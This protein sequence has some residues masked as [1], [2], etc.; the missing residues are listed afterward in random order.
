[1][2]TVNDWAQQQ[3]GNA[4]LGDQ[5]RTRRAVALGAQIATRPAAGLPG[6]SQ[7]WSDLKAAY[8]L[9]HEDDVTHAALSSPHWR[10][11]CDRAT[12]ANGPVLFVQDGSQ[13]DFTLH[14]AEGLGRIGNERGRGI[15]IHSTLVLLPGDPVTV[16]GLAHQLPWVRDGKPHKRRET[17][18]QRARRSGRESEHWFGALQAIGRVPEGACCVSVGDRESDIFGYWEKARELG[19]ECL[20]RLTYPRRILCEDGSVGSLLDWA[21]QLTPQAWQ[22]MALRTRPDRTARSAMLSLAWAGTQ[23]LP[24]RNDPILHGHAPLPVWVLRVWEDP[25][26]AGEPPLEWLL[27]STLPIENAAQ[28]SERVNWYRH[29]WVIEQYHKALKT[30]CGMERSQ[31]KDAAALTRLLGLLSIV[32][33]HLLQVETLARSV[34]DLPASQAIDRQLLE[35]LCHLRQIDPAS[36]TVYQFWREVAKLGGFLARKHDGEPGWQTLWRG[37][38]YLYPRFEGYLLAQRCG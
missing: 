13:L 11:T 10:Q 6:Q 1:M 7:S 34:P 36:M 24:P 38:H 35:F 8:R 17:R 23:V 29:R 12:R 21:R 26:P 28:A 30:G 22:T 37:W 20:L 33:V 16:L 32:A 9:L 2:P 27:L 5:R 3:W 15:L 25:A 18:T 14:D 4:E 31:L 19:W